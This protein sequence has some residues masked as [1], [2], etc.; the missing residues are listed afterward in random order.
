MADAAQLHE[1]EAQVEN[2]PPDEALAA[3]RQLVEI[4]GPL[5][6]E[7]PAKPVEADRF[8]RGRPDRDVDDRVRLYGATS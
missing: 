2:A 4:L 3:A 5:A 8:A 1:L 7:A 6:E